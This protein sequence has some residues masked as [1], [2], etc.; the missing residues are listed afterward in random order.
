MQALLQS[1]NQY[2]EMCEYERNLSA[3]TIK[4]YHFARGTCDAS[5]IAPT[6]P[7]SQKAT[8]YT[9]RVVPDGLSL[10]SIFVNIAAL[11]FFALCHEEFIKADDGADVTLVGEQVTDY[12]LCPLGFALGD[13]IP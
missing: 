11:T 7:T 4:A 13:G 9:L 10:V 2:L 12:S 3:D 5:V 8:Q 6:L 1:I